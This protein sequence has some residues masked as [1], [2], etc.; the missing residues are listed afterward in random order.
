M[1]CEKTDGELSL[2]FNEATYD[3]AKLLADDRA[4]DERNTRE[5]QDIRN[6]L[7]AVIR[8]AAILDD[9]LEQTQRAAAAERMAEVCGA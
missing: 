4:F 1:A 9:R 2:D 7:S 5:L 8:R 6:A 3:C